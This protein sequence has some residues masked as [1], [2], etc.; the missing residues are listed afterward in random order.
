MRTVFINCSMVYSFGGGG[1]GFFCCAIA[2]DAATTSV[3]RISDKR[4]SR[5]MGHSFLRELLWI[6]SLSIAFVLFCG[7]KS[8]AST[9]RSMPEV[10]KRRAEV[11]ELG[12]CS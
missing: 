3:K 6:G 9:I 5:F 4:L 8:A 12:S 11:M 10:A 2:V 1:A 7:Y